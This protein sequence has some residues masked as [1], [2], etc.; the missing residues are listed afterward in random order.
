MGSIIDK[1]R[2][3]DMPCQYFDG[4]MITVKAVGTVGPWIAA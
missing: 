2:A 1:E 3:E 4:R